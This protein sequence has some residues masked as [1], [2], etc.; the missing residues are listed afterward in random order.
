MLK[1]NYWYIAVVIFMLI[2]FTLPAGAD[3]KTFPNMVAFGDSLSDHHGIESYFGIRSADN[4][5]GVRDAWTNGDVWLEY[6]AKLW[7]VD[8]NSD[9]FDNNAIAGAKTRG[10]ENPDIQALS[11]AQQIPQLGLVGQVGLYLSGDPSFTANNTLF[12]IW[13]GGNDLLEYGRGD[14]TAAGETEL[15][16][17]A[18]DNIN[19]SM[20]ELATEGGLYFL[21]LTLPDI[22]KSPAYNQRTEAEIQAASALSS[23]FN[24]ELQKALNAFKTAYPAVTIYTFDVFSFLN[25]TIANNTFT[26]STGTYLQLDSEGDPTGGTNEPASDYLF[27]DT[28]HPTTRAHELLAVDVKS[29]TFDDDDDDTCFISIATGGSEERQPVGNPLIICVVSLIACISLRWYLK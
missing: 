6:L 17:N 11:D 3:A 24:S 13:I 25:R 19:S 21:V 7:N 12:V 20:G 23:T 28:I 14:S 10:H 15:I 27:W 9:N 4:P 8:V 16:Q 2:G 29:T 26:N 1:R 5:T 22:G 18:I